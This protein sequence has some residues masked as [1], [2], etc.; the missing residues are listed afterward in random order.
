MIFS[1]EVFLS[2]CITINLG[3]GCLL[4]AFKVFLLEKHFVFCLISQPILLGHSELN[5]FINIKQLF[6]QQ[7]LLI[8]DR[9]PWRVL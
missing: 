2:S 3:F 7:R 9:A 8:W 1:K 4:T 5:T 6:T